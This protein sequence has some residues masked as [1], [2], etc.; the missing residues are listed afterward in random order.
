MDLAWKREEAA[1]KAEHE[2]QTREMED[3]KR[4]AREFEESKVAEVKR[5][6]E[7]LRN[8]QRGPRIS[9]ASCELVG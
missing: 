4:E 3:R 2:E 1:R 8:G 9:I 6:Y 5:T 7:T